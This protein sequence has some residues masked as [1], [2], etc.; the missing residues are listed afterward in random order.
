MPTHGLTIGPMQAG[1]A[2]QLRRI[3]AAAFSGE[4]FTEGMYGPSRLE[5][6]RHL[7]DDYRSFPGPTDQVVVGTCDDVVVSFAA[8][9]PPGACGLCRGVAAD[10]PADAA[11]AEQIEHEFARRCRAA[12]LAADLPPEHARITTVATEPFLAGT[13]IGGHVVAALVDHAWASGAGC[14]ALECLTSRG[15]FYRRLGFADVVEFDD[16]GGDGL[17]SMLMVAHRRS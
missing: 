11:V 16:P 13:G 3:V 4:P 17:R 12:H 10:P 7:L 5:R 2:P 6:Y 15:A 8:M 9:E 14:L 1:H